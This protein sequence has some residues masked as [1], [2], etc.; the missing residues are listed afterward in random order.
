M[1]R[2]ASI[3][4][5]M[6]VFLNSTI[7]SSEITLGNN[8]NKTRVLITRANFWFRPLLINV[9]YNIDRDQEKSVGTLFIRNLEI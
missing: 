3:N 5:S 6:Y 1:D 4:V 9:Q 7:C 8:C 2:N